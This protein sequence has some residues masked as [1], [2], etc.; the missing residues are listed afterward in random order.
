MAHTLEE[1]KAVCTIHV[2]VFDN[3]HPLWGT[4]YDGEVWI[5]YGP[6][7]NV[8]VHQDPTPRKSMETVERHM[9]TW[10]ASRVGRQTITDEILLLAGDP[11]D[12]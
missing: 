2:K 3:K 1:I 11:D 9:E 8:Q 7:E 12:E 5:D 4:A 10:I 6:W